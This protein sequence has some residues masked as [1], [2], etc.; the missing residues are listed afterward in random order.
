MAMLLVLAVLAA[1]LVAEER[2]RADRN[3]PPDLRRLSTNWGLAI[4]NWL[5]AAVVPL[6]ALAAA[7]A[8]PQGPLSALPAWLAAA[9]LLL[10]RSLGTYGLHRLFHAVP[11][12]WRVHRVHHA[13]PAFDLSTGLRNHPL[14]ALAAFL[15]AAGI[16]WLLA[17]PPA[18]VV[19]VDGLILAAAFWTHAAVLLPPRLSAMVERLFVTPRLH[20]IHHSRDAADHDRNFGDVLIL[21]DRL[22][23]T[24]KPARDGAIR[25]GLNG[26]DA[27]ARS[28]LHQLALPFRS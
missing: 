4:V 14:E 12:L 21:W 28:L 23:G 11:L 2:G 27:G 5:L 6:G 22:F 17:P 25:V 16:S 19:A 24:L 10:A 15:T 13:D 7:M 3:A 26:E 9:P 8:A 20:L 1:L 18:A